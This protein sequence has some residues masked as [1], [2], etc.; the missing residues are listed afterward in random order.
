LGVLD[1]FH[2]VHWAIVTLGTLFFVV[3]AFF[4]YAAKD[5]SGDIFQSVV[6]ELFVVGL[7]WFFIFIVVVAVIVRLTKPKNH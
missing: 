2:K 7:F 3:V 1:G 6:A 5:V 4:W